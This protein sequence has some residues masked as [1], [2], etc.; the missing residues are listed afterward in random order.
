MTL[1]KTILLL[2]HAK[3]AW[4]DTALSDHDRP[5]NR[6]GERAAKAIGDHLAHHG[7]RPDLVLCSTAMRARQTLAPVIKR[8]G[9]RAP[10]IALEDT[11]YLASEGNL[12]ERLQAVDDD[13][14]TVLL[15][16]HND[17]IWRLAETLAGRGSPA[18]LAALQEKYPTG[19]L[20]TLELP[21]GPWCDLAAGSGDLVAFVRPRDLMR[22]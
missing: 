4:S 19:T 9:T 13:V 22:G 11:L 21:D 5:L 6:R 8:L 20:A 14:A 7:P 3:S 12:L 17:G 18:H 16:G 10:P 15:V 2:R 1:V